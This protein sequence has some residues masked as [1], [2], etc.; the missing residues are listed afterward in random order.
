MSIAKIYYLLGLLL[1]ASCASNLIKYDCEN[2][3]IYRG[4]GFEL[5]NISI[6]YNNKI[7]YLTQKNGIKT[8]E[9]DLYYIYHY[10]EID[11]LFH[12]RSN[13][14]VIILPNTKYII[15]NRSNGDA[16]NQN[17]TL[18]TDSV[19]NIICPY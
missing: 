16:V 5:H 13:E 15:T 3:S 18:F 4:S 19:G 7:S 12:I 17:I 1:C 10:F 9:V 11:T 14:P 2:H 6:E 8:Y